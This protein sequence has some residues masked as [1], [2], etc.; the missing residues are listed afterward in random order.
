MWVTGIVNASRATRRYDEGEGHLLVAAA[1]GRRMS[2]FT[3]LAFTSALALAPL[4]CAAPKPQV[5]A[6]VAQLQPAPATQLQSAP[7]ASGV[8][9]W[10]FR[11]T[12]DQGDMR[13]EQEEWHLLQRG[14]RVE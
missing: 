8:W 6:P 14:S 13:V 11:S 10:M 2:R 7:D 12:D 4:G 5:K 9:D 3:A 1:G